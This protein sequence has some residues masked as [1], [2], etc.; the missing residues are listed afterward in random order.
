MAPTPLPQT[1]VEGDL[2]EPVPR[3]D[4]GQAPATA[5]GTERGPD[6]HPESVDQQ[7]TPELGGAAGF[8]GRRQVHRVFD[9]LPIDNSTELPAWSSSFRA[10]VDMFEHGVDECAEHGAGGQPDQGAGPIGADRG[11]WLW[12]ICG[13]PVTSVGSIEIAGSLVGGTAVT[14]RQVVGIRLRHC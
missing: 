10:E 13:R 11:G 5:Q 3:P 9:Q 7:L 8:S 1:E 4:V 2:V 14:Q 6:G 12:P